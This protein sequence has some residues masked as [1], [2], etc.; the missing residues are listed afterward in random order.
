M[1]NVDANNLYGNALRY[2]LPIADFVYIDETEYNT[3]DWHHIDTQGN[4]GYFLV[5]DLCYPPDIHQRTAHLPLAPEVLEI[6]YNM[7]TD[8]SKALNSR[9]NLACIPD[10]L[11][12]DAFMSCTKLMA[13]CF[14]RYN[15][16]LHFA[17]LQLYLQL[18]LLLMRVHRVIR[19]TQAPLF[20]S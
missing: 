18:G 9:K 6:N 12:P 5:C 3:I 16:V 19:F 11:N 4:T 1:E 14:D 20:R 17:A 15:Y 8:Y 2:P 13:T 10:T 7:L